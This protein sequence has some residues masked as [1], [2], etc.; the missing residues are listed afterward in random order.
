MS[1]ARIGGRKLRVERGRRGGN[2]AGLFHTR[3]ILEAMMS[4]S[5]LCRAE[6]AAADCVGLVTSCSEGPPNRGRAGL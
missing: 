5:P 1:S 3:R 4:A 2:D 6:L